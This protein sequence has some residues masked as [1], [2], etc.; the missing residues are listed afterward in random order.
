MNQTEKERR[1]KTKGNRKILVLE[2]IDYDGR[3]ATLL[4]TSECGFGQMTRTSP[5]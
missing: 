4:F 1:I 2:R 5:L 3:M